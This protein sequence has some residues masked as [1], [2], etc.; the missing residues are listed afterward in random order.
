M[1][2][3]HTAALEDAT[4]SFF[5]DSLTRLSAGEI[6][7]LVGGA[8]AYARYSGIHRG[9][10]DLDLFVRPSDV[11]RTLALFEEAGYHTEVPFPHWLAKI[12]RHDRFVDLIFSSGNG[13]ARVDDLWFDHAAKQEILGIDVCLC[14]P[15]EMIWSKAFIQERERFDGADVLHLIRELGPT[16][17]WQRLLMR[18]GDNWPVLLSHIVLFRYVYPNRRQA[19]PAWV[20]DELAQRFLELPPKP[21][22]KVCR[23][24]LLSREQYLHDLEQL[25]YEDGRVEPHGNMTVDETERWTAA[26]E[27]K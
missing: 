15:E 7:F 1:E 13:L 27:R 10:K 9:T 3:C 2:T 22:V 4:T 18:F 25:G 23:G 6:P 20:V 19:V 12:Y 11:A 14:P 8:F 5:V 24:P 21:N 26:I 17:D 16:L